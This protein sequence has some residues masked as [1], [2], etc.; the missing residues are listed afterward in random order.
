MITIIIALL[1]RSDSNDLQAGRLLDHRGVHD[2]APDDHRVDAL[3]GLEE[4]LLRLVVLDFLQCVAL[5]EHKP[6]RIKP[7]RIER[8]ALSLQNQNHYI[9]LFFDTTPF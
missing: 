2:V 7:G 6:G 9:C 5:G 8:A 3:Y 4:L 1:I